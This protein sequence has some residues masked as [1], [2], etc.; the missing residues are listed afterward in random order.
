M[1]SPPLSLPKQSHQHVSEEDNVITF[2]TFK[3]KQQSK[4][5]ENSPLRQDCELIGVYA[6]AVTLH[7]L[8]PDSACMVTAV[9]R[10]ST[11]VMCLS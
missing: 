8:L 9:N 3:V 11:A 6:S 5:I 7:A 1:T 4:S 10:L 2:G